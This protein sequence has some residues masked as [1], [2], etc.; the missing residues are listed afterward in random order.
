MSE[1]KRKNF[2]GEFKAKVSIEVLCCVLTT[3]NGPHAP[4]YACGL[5]ASGL[6][7]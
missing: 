3:L 7:R 5:C 4:R 2:K 1:A 6:G